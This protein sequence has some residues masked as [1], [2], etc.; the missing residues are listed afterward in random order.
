MIELKEA[1]FS[2]Y[3]AIARLHAESWQQ[4]YRG[5]WSDHFLNNE[6]YQ[7]LLQKWHKKLNPPP[8]NQYVTTAWSGQQIAGFSCLL[9]D[10]DKGFGSLLDNLHVSRKLQK[11][12]IGKILM[13]NCAD[14][15]WE[16]AQ[17][18]K[19]YL[20]VYEANGNARDFYERL[21]GQKFET[22]EVQNE[23][24]TKA[25]ACRYIWNDVSVIK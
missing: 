13:R 11:S 12:G 2:D 10:D 9:L 1:Q 21:G 22:V 6:V 7:F 3:T 24:G 8:R 17:T 20:W 4:H 23:D 16:K 25:Q 18:H 5:I 15:V 19:M 14:I